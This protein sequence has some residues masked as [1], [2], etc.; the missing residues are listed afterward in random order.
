MAAERVESLR[1]K[2]VISEADSRRWLE[3]AS[4]HVG[5]EHLAPTTT[6]IREAASAHQGAPLAIWLGTLLD[7]IPESVLIGASLVQ[8]AVSLSLLAAVFLSNF[9][10]SL[11]SSVAMRR[12]GMRFGRI[13]WMWLSLLALSGACTVLG[14]LFFVGASASVNAALQGVGAGAMLTMIADT[15][16]PEAS[17]K[18]GP[19]TGIATLA[20][21][22]AAVFFKTLG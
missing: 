6:E 11:S 14:R 10:E 19:I 20:G 5:E 22:L 3:K 13:L 15:M 17:E 12:G 8:G 9:P 4:Q 1:S 7:G 21:F 2:S 16:L 18:G